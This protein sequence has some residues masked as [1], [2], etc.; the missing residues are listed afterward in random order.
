M[1]YCS[2]KNYIQE[3]QQVAEA[4]FDS[5]IIHVIGNGIVILILMM[6]QINHRNDTQ[7]LQLPQIAHI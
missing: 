3:F 2:S 1:P 5:E 7:K 4:T 6:L